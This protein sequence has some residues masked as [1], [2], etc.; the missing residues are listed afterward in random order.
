MLLFNTMRVICDNHAKCLINSVVIVLCT[1]DMFVV[2]SYILYNILIKTASQKCWET[3][4]A[5][6]IYM[7]TEDHTQHPGFE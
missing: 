3:P 6:S 2:L 7:R 5:G 4:G 1:P